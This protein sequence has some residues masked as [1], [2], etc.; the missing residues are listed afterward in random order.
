MATLLGLN[1]ED[2]NNVKTPDSKPDRLDVPEAV[3]L[4]WQR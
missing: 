1:T 2:P 4:E 3:K